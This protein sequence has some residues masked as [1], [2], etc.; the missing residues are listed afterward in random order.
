[1]A[2][3]IKK[4][5]S[6]AE[7]YYTNHD[8]DNAIR[9]F[10]EAIDTDPT[11]ALYYKRGL[12]YYN[13][14]KDD[15]GISD[16]TKAIELDPNNTDAYY[17][18]GV[19]HYYRSEFDLAIAD[20]KKAIE[21][22][23]NHANAHCDFGLIY[24]EKKDYENALVH[25]NASISINPK[26]WRSYYNRALIHYY[27]KVDTT[28]ALNDLSNAI[29]LNP[30]Y[31]KAY[32]L[33]GVVYQ[34]MGKTEEAKA[35]YKKALGLDP[36][37]REARKALNNLEGA[38]AVGTNVQ[39]KES[40]KPE[41]PETNFS[42]VAGMNELKERLKFSIIE[43]LKNP[44]LAKKY[45]R[46]V[47]GGIVLYG[48]P[49]CGKTYITMALAGETKMK[50]INI[51]VSD[52]L[53]QWL[54][55]SEK[56]LH[57]AFETAR[58][59]A[60][61]IL[62]LDEIDGLGWRRAEAQHSWERSMIAQLLVEIDQ[63]DKKNENILVLGA[64]NAPWFIDEA[65]KRSGRFGK[66]IYV[67]PPDGT[68]RE[69]LFKMYLNSIPV[70]KHINYKKFA[71]QTWHFSCADV[72]AVCEAAAEAAYTQSLKSGKEAPVTSDMIKDAIKKERSDLTEWF[73]SLGRM[74][75]GEELKELYPELSEDLS[76]M[77]KMYGKKT[78]KTDGG[79]FG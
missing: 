67:N 73:T 29:E 69:A 79:M 60:P 59:N 62:F 8:Y 30:N 43:P 18:R 7:R 5:L 25:Y 53:D 75:I 74:I 63:I 77:Q 35:D 51:K 32:D 23:P 54:G 15:F 1:M 9:W 16:F 76:R 28:S 56:N 31:A 65:L 12:C 48:P 78:S 41:I 19:S 2:N 33:R 70:E 34:E 71:E 17:Y 6:E 27:Y 38:Q 45:K 66:L 11:S 68:A 26:F 21:I 4:V 39:A 13:K 55:N 52:I 46:R 3:D 49:G 37:L 57:A 72:Q 36:L 24:Y 50:M 40:F 22:N 61:C 42:N 44:E 10:S 47:G 20:Y 14:G 58:K 64:T